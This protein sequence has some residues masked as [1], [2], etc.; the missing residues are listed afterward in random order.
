MPTRKRRIQEE[1]NLEIERGNRILCEK[2]LKAG[3]R[4]QSPPQDSSSRELS[5]PPEPESKLRD[6]L[7]AQNKFA[8]AYF[9]DIERTREA[10]R[11][12]S[13]PRR[14]EQ[15]SQ[16][17]QRITTYRKGRRVIVEVRTGSRVHYKQF[18]TQ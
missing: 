16:G 14:L 15:F 6:I 11:Y 8:E 7:Q 10:L 18:E 4:R 2:L 9:Q 17:G 12:E 13:A 1:R 3:P 5:L